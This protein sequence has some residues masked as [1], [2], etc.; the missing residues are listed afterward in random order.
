MSCGGIIQSRKWKRKV[1]P[2]T[3][4][5]EN[6]QTYN[7]SFAQPP[8]QGKI[9]CSALKLRN[10]LKKL[11]TFDLNFHQQHNHQPVISQQSLE[12]KLSSKLTILKHCESNWTKEEKLQLPTS[13]GKAGSS[14]KEREKAKKGKWTKLSLRKALTVVLN[15]KK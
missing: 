11:A 9:V 12:F 8:S 1:Q 10:H 4:L 5:R 3:T 6:Q 13:F 7:P 14:E 15:R 2:T